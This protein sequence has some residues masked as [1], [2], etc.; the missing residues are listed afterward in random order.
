MRIMGALSPAFFTLIC[1]DTIHYEFKQVL[2]KCLGREWYQ[3][4]CGMNL[5]KTDID[6]L[7]ETPGYLPLKTDMFLSKY[8]FPSFKSDRETAEFLVGVLERV[9]LPSIAAEV[10]RDLEHELDIEGA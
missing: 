5:P 4:A 2:K 1:A 8:R 7:Q 10:K 9:S 3:L 6:T